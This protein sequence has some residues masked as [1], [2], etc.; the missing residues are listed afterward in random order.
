M[1]NAV[2]LPLGETQRFYEATRAEGRVVWVGLENR[3]AADSGS[4]GDCVGRLRHQAC[5]ATF[6]RLGSRDFHFGLLVV[7]DW[8]VNRGRFDFSMA[9]QDA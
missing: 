3:T 1:Q 9:A 8:R 6:S 2:R 4:P 7:A 5:L